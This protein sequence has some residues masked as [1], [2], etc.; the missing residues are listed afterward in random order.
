[1][2]SFTSTTC[3]GYPWVTAWIIARPNS[4]KVVA[5]LKGTRERI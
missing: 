1:M 5:A 2:M 3:F 4:A